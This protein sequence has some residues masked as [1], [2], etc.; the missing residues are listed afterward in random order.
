[1]AQIDLLSSVLREIRP[2]PGTAKSVESAAEDFRLEIQKILDKIMERGVVEV[3]GSV[4]K[5]T[6]LEDGHDIDIF[7]FYPEDVSR[8]KLEEYT[9]RLGREWA[10]FRGARY[11]ISY[12]EH[13]YVKV[14]VSLGKIELGVDVVGAYQI[15]QT[16]NLKSSVDR[17][18]FHTDYVRKRMTSTLRDQVLLTKKFMK[19]TGVYGSE[20]RVGGFSGLL[21]EVLTI[22]SGSF[23]ELVKSAS[24]WST[25]QVVD[26]EKL[27]PDAGKDFQAPLVV[28]DPT[29][30]SRN[31]GAAVTVEK[32]STFVAASR[33]FLEKP[34]INF[35]FPT[36]RKPFSR[37]ELLRRLESRGTRILLL[38]FKRPD[39]IDDIIFPQITRMQKTLRNQLE[40]NGFMLSGP[41][42]GGISEEEGSISVLFELAVWQLPRVEKRQG[43]S[44]NMAEHAKKFLEKHS[45]SNPYI[46]GDRWCV[47][48]RRKFT[49]AEDLLEYILGDNPQGMLPSHLAD[50]IR[51][52]WTM[53]TDRKAI[54]SAGPGARLMMT[55]H[56]ARL[57]PWQVIEN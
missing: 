16:T 37:G 13:P 31:A 11:Q 4:A 43:P 55:E 34:G 18:R 52:G 24:G 8:E 51:N 15:D 41:E 5:G 7:A 40:D 39:V 35:F 44:V 32:V 14:E 2:S 38:E 17:T 42:N 54:D 28:V 10:E 33:A 25:G 29:D 57:Y 21:C 23:M 46:E 12:A 9:L 22:D 6:Y 45:R 50:A 49:R 26:V 48:A 3:Q 27:N 20:I 19:G 53:R 30:G 1:L 56:F 47:D 36:R